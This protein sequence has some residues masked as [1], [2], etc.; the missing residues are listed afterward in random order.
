MVMEL[1]GLMLTYKATAYDYIHVFILH[2]LLS[3]WHNLDVLY[4][5]W[6][7]LMGVNTLPVMALDSW[8]EMGMQLTSHLIIIGPNIDCLCK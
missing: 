7:L 6:T 5:F 3:L 8:N 1:V 4:E 2:T